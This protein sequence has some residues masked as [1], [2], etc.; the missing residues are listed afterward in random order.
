[1]LLFFHIDFSIAIAAEVCAILERISDF[2]PSTDSVAPR[3]LKLATVSRS[4]PLISIRSCMP[5]ELLVMS[6][7]FSALMSIP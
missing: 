2:D 5:F 1:M 4:F 3:Y 6:F 7:V